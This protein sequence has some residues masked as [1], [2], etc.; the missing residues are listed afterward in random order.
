MTITDTHWRLVWDYFAYPH[1]FELG[2]INTCILYMRQLRHTA[3]ISK[4]EQDIHS[5]K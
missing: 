5:K 4:L 3:V 1:I 2:V